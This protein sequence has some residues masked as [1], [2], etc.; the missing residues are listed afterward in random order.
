[1]DFDNLTICLRTSFSQRHPSEAPSL[2]SLLLFVRFLVTFENM[3]CNR[4]IEYYHFLRLSLIT[5]EQVCMS[6]TFLLIYLISSNFQE[7]STVMCSLWTIHRSIV[8]PNFSNL[9]HIYTHFYEILK[10]VIPPN[11]NSFLAHCG[12]SQFCS[13][14]MLLISC[15]KAICVSISQNWIEPDFS[16]VFPNFCS[17][18]SSYFPQPSTTISFFSKLFIIQCGQH[19]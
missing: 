5:M 2:I 9:L 14:R 13:C 8:I 3:T 11:F 1:M 15:F 4:F 6:C 7:S 17:R 10:I 19:W 16:H 18:C 12:P